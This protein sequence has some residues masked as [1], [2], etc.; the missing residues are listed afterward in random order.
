VI[1]RLRR[2]EFIPTSVSVEFFSRKQ[3]RNGIVVLSLTVRPTLGR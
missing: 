2:K 1:L 3:P